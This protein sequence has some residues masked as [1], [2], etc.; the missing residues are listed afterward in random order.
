[1]KTLIIVAHPDLDNS[2]IHKRWIEELNKYPEKYTIHHLDSHYVNGKLDIASE[3]KLIEAHGNLILQFPIFWFNCPPIM[4]QWLDEVLIPGW[5]YAT[6][7]D[8]EGE[9]IDRKVALAVTTGMAEKN[10]SKEGRFGYSLKE[11]LAPFETT[12]K[13]IHANYRSFYA[14]YGVERHPSPA[15]IDQS[16]KDYIQF[17]NQM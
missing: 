2:V 17:I 7:E 11:L 8:K 9:F 6:G 3:K 4:K 12:L 16:A 1:M 14:F 5:A 10:Y 13:S 15:K